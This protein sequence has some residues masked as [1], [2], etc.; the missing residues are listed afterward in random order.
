MEAQI[1]GITERSISKRTGQQTIYKKVKENETQTHRLVLTIQL[2]T[3]TSIRTNI[4]LNTLS[5]GTGS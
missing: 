1:K 2:D 5:L 4:A 3:Q